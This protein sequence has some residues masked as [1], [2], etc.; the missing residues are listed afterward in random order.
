M[1]RGRSALIQQVFLT[2]PG[3]YEVKTLNFYR[4]FPGDYARDTKHLTLA[5]HGAYTLLLD[6]YYST[7]KPIPSLE[8]AYA[9]CDAH[10]G[11]EVKVVKK[12]LLCFFERKG[13]QWVNRRAEKEVRYAQDKRKSA[14]N[15]AKARWEPSER[16]ANA[17]GTQSKE[18]TVYPSKRNAPRLQT[19]DSRKPDRAVV[20]VN[21]EAAAAFLAIGFDKP[22]GNLAFQHA[23]IDEFRKPGEWLTMK[24]E[25]A[26]Q[27]CQNEGIGIPPQFYE[28]KRDV[29]ARENAAVRKVPL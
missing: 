23:F 21:G 12:V 9:L 16:N 4:R 19:P 15:S 6:Y 22:F 18:G 7:E 13:K 29:E 24:L 11:G 5:E 2:I 14:K 10:T 1:G 8:F 17:L 26:I 25:A 20:V 28:A 3:R 27:R